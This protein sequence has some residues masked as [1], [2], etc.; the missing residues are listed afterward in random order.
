MQTILEESK[1]QVVMDDACYRA[2]YYEL[3]KKIDSF[4][5]R[6]EDQICKA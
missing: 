3:Q 6:I 2:F 4:E 5:A 1:A